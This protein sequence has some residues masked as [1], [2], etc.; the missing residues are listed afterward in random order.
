M[1]AKAGLLRRV[2]HLSSGP[3]SCVPGWPRE[4][5]RSHSGRAPRIACSSIADGISGPFLLGQWPVCCN[6]ALAGQ[7]SPNAEKLGATA[8]FFGLWLA[9]GGESA[10]VLFAIDRL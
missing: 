2:T 6:V 5:A 10:K 9:N 7:K 3:T 4:K 1:Y 8:F